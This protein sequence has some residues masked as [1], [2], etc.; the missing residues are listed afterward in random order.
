MLTQMK[1]LSLCLVSLAGVLTAQTGETVYLRAVLLPA[2]EVLA[3]NNAARGVAD[4]I[5]SAV[6]DAS[7]QIVS[8]NL[9]VLLRVT[10][11]AA[12]TATG[13]NLH[14]GTAGQSV[15]AALSSGLAS[16][17]TRALQSGSDS[18]RIPIAIAGDNGATLGMLRS[19]FQDPS[20]F[21]L[22]L[23]TTDQANGL[24]RGQLAKAQIA[25]TMA[26]MASGNVVPATADTG[27]GFGQW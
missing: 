17:N 15:P 26:V 2:N 19:V 25:V 22:N 16:G 7:G 27:T 3:I 23:S 11:P 1:S 8:G 12:I 5:A 24:M 4:V 6:R 21:Y 14:N 10:L 18:L 13:L 20:K 9:D